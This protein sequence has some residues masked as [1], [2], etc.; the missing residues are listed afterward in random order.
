MRLGMVST[1]EKRKEIMTGME[2][3]GVE[4]EDWNDRDE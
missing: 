1:W 3:K 4:E 2:A